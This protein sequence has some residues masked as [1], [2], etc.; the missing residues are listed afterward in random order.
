MEPIVLLTYAFSFYAGYNI[1][2]DMLDHFKMMNAISEVR[3]Q[4]TQLKDMQ[5]DL[6]ENIKKDLKELKKLNDLKDL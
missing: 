6:L 5:A 3:L 2:N 1:V 4:I